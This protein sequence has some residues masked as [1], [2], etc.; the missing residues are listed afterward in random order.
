[1]NQIDKTIKNILGKTKK[2]GGRNDWDGDG[3]PNKKDCQPRNVMRQDDEHVAIDYVASGI[4]PMAIF[5]SQGMTPQFIQ[6]IMNY[7]KQKGLIVDI[8]TSVIDGIPIK[9]IVVR[10][11]N[12]PYDK[13]KGFYKYAREQGGIGIALGYPK[14]AV[15]GWKQQGGP[16]GMSFLQAKRYFVSQGISPSD[17]DYLE[18]VPV[19][20]NVQEVRNEI[21]KRKFNTKQKPTVRLW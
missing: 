20:M 14:K 2:R 18:F 1:M 17:F 4:K 9:D 8:E 7:A 13:N 6:E 19:G 11:P 10:S 3:V 16:G 5:N 21:N 15:T 12:T